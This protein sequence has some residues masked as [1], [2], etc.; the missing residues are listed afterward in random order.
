[1]TRAEDF[2]E[3]FAGE[4]RLEV[5]ASAIPAVS[6]AAF[7]ASSA[8]SFAISLASAVSPD[9]VAEGGRVAT[10]VPS[11]RSGT[12]GMV[13]ASG[14][15]DAAGGGVAIGAVAAGVLNGAVPGVSPDKP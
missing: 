10:C 13:W 3:S 14:N 2:P 12:A 4:S 6:L 15:S 9:A 11:G 8:G 1:M 7:G 5:D